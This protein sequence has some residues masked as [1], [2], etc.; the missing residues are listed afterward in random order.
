MEASDGEPGTDSVD[1]FHHLRR[2]HMAGAPDK[3]HGRGTA[4]VHRAH[5]QGGLS[6]GEAGASPV[7]LVVGLRDVAR[8]PRLPAPAGVGEGAAV[9]DSQGGPRLMATKR[10]MPLWTLAALLGMCGLLL[11]LLLVW[12]GR[13]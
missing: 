6:D 4:P 3:A 11:G 10:T 9:G 2:P 8:T 12:A 13:G 1:R 5:G 7:R